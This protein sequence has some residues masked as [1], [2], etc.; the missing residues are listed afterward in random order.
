MLGRRFKETFEAQGVQD[1]EARSLPSNHASCKRNLSS[2]EVL[3][4]DIPEMRGAA[5]QDIV[6]LLD[7]TSQLNSAPSN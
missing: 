7:V 4:M 2:P 3:F 6:S 1:T 5:L